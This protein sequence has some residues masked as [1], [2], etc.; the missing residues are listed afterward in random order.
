MWRLV[1][2]PESRSRMWLLLVLLGCAHLVSEGITTAQSRDWGRSPRVP[3]PK[4]LPKSG[5]ACET[6]PAC[7]VMGECAGIAPYCHA[8]SEVRCRASASCVREGKCS[9][10][11]FKCV[12]ARDVDCRTA[13]VCRDFGRCSLQGAV[14]VAVSLADCRASRIC[15]HS[16]RCEP[17][18]GTC[19][20]TNDADCAASE[21]CRVDNQC[22]YS[23]QFLDCRCKPGIPC[24]SFEIE[25]ARLMADETETSVA[26]AAGP[27]PKPHAKEGAGDYLL[28]CRAP[29]ARS[30]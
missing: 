17:I 14:C 22:V 7:W 15:A 29:S 27:A 8:D 24:G 13:M 30:S 12:A 20:Q 10:G 2:E 16:G 23:E 26:P 5:V 19:R 1:P 9:L 4:P 11:G 18:D 3:Y 25:M 28:F 6:T 21:I